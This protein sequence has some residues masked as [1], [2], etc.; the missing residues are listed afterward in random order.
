MQSYLV[1]LLLDI[2]GVGDRGAIGPRLR[3]LAGL[4]SSSQGK[5]L[6]GNMTIG[7]HVST[8]LITGNIAKGSEICCLQ[9]STGQ[10]IIN[11]Q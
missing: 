4:P 8:V 1:L 5:N 9:K 2:D 3:V 11:E 7:S 6:L 10:W